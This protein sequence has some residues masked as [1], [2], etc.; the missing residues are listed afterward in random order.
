MGSTK[1]LDAFTYFFRSTP[2]GLIVAHTYQ[3][4]E[5]MSTWIFECTDE[6]WKNIG[7]EV[8]NE[9]DTVSKLAEILKTN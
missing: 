1:P 4:E 2:Y 6:T 3:Y 7:F 5:G 9:A 8:E